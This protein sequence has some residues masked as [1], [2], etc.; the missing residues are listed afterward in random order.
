MENIDQYQLQRE[1][2]HLFNKNQ[3]IPRIKSEFISS[4]SFDFTSYFQHKDIPVAFGFDLMVQMALHKRVSLPTLAS[5]MDKHFDNP[6]ETVDMLYRCADAD[7]MDWSPQ[8]R[9]FIVRV[10]IS[11]E[12]QAE[13]DRFQYPLPMVVQPKKLQNNS[14]IGLLNSKGSVILKKNHHEDDVCLDH[15]NRLNRIRFVINEQTAQ[16]VKNSWRNLDKPKHGESKDDFQRRKKA[17]EKYDRT[18]KD[19]MKLLTQY[20]DVFHLT[21]KYD[22]RLRTYCQGY[23]VNYQGAA[24]NKAVIEFADK[25]VIHD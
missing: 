3:L 18:A 4:E 17:F 15:L 11:D 24:W 9:L 5:I 1:L 14:D 13:L 19:I 2:E 16:L 6:Q 22:K 10:T 8:F 12:V 20:S 25:E 21:H 23:H 7:L